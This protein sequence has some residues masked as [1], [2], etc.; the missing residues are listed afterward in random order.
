M[1]TRAAT[2]RALPGNAT[3]NRSIA[4]SHPMMYPGS[5]ES[6]LPRLPDDSRNE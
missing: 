3:T 6:K 2:H 4:V 1:L 5:T